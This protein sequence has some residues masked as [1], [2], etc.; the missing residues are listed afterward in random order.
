MET[1]HARPDD[2]RTARWLRLYKVR[3]MLFPRILNLVY[4]CQ[5]LELHE[6]RCWVWWRWV[7]RR[8]DRIITA[9][10]PILGMLYGFSPNGVGVS[11]EN[12]PAN[13]DA[14]PTFH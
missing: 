7:M 13:V 3:C 4:V 14:K 5:A 11:E 6:V 8:K 1:K 9:M 10:E 2:P 12:D